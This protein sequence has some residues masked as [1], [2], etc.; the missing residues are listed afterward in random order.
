MSSKALVSEM[1]DNST[2]ALASNVKTSLK[3]G[4]PAYERL[5]NKLEEDFHISFVYVM[6]PEAENSSTEKVSN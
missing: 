2:K 4:K 1:V 6:K 5:V 3:D